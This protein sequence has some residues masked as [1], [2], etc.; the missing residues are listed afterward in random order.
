MIVQ[1]TGVTIETKVQCTEHLSSILQLFTLP[2][3]YYLC[4]LPIVCRYCI[5]Q[6]VYSDIHCIH[7]V[8]VQVTQDVHAEL[9]TINNQ[10][11]M[12]PQRQ[13]NC[14]HFVVPSSSFSLLSFEEI[15]WGGGLGERNGREWVFAT[16]NKQVSSNSG[17]T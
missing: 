16:F 6:R 10:G 12:R 5:P 9:T 7:T 11:Y 3:T 4:T 17:K 14:L 15:C 2:I 13:S 1:K 8:S